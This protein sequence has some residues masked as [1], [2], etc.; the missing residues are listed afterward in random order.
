GIERRGWLV[1]QPDGSRYREQTGDRQ[2]PSLTGGQIGGRQIGKLGKVDCLQGRFDC[3]AIAEKSA[4]E[5][6]ILANCKRGLHRVLVAEIVCL[7]A[8]R[9]VGFAAFEDESTRGD[10]HQTG[11]Q[12]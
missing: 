6:Q 7:L 4:P 5:L 12:A 9:N 1:K 2:S 8:N 10:S 3:T 11:N